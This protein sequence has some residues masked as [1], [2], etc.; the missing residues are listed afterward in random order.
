METK[1]AAVVRLPLVWE[2][3]EFR[4]VSGPGER[5]PRFGR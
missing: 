1:R 5:W 2:E 3:R 4:L